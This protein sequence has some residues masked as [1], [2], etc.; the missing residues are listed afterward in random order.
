[1][2][3]ITAPINPGMSGAPVINSNGYVV[4]IVASTFRR[5]AL[6]QLEHVESVLKY[7]TGKK[8][9]EAQEAYQKAVE[10]YQKAIESQRKALEQTFKSLESQTPDNSD[11]VTKI[12]QLQRA[13]ASEVASK[14][15]DILQKYGEISISI[16]G[17]EKRNSLIV[18]AGKNYHD[19]VE[20]LI[21]SLD[22]EQA[23]L[24]A[25]ERK[26]AAIQ[27]E[28]EVKLNTQKLLLDKAKE[29]QRMLDESHQQSFTLSSEGM[30][31]AIPINDIKHAAEQ[32]IQHGKVDYGW[33]GVDAKAV[34][35]VVRAQL[36]IKKGH[37]V[38]IE[39]VTPS[40]PAEKAGLKQWD[41]ILQFGDTE[42]DTPKTLQHLVRRTSPG[43]KVSIK[44]IREGKP[45][46]LTLEIGTAT[47]K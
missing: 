34:P 5:A 4:G 2:F 42:V 25:Q 26:I 1:M 32:L 28:L 47:H 10:A 3:Q 22:V 6:P 31:F 45:L 23:E 18:E 37:G 46:T 24:L 9:K 30:N 12:Y 17:D 8:S 35:P 29:V 20:R 7:Q 16:V 39:S 36:G 38:L 11:Y 13:N 19:A 15:K 33:L 14:L 44:V 21:E 41:V 27:K 40:S 43:Q